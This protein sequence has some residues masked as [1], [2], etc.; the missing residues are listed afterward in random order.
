[1][2][3]RWLGRHV[4][5][6]SFWIFG[7]RCGSAGG[8]IRVDL[9][10][11]RTLFESVVY[12]VGRRRK[13]FRV[14]RAVDEGSDNGRGVAQSCAGE[15][16]ILVQLASAECTSSIKNHQQLVMTTT[17]PITPPQ[18]GC[19]FALGILVYSSRRYERKRLVLALVVVC[20]S[21]VSIRCEG[22]NYLLQL[23]Y[24]PLAYKSDY[25]S[26]MK[27]DITTWTAGESVSS[28]SPPCKPSSC[29]SAAGSSGN[30]AIIPSADN[31][32]LYGPLSAGPD[33]FG[34]ARMSPSEER[35]RSS[36]QRDMTGRTI[37]AIYPECV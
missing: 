19:L 15:W 12:Q 20:G 14:N 23:I 33:K 31:Y 7:T 2:R 32:K 29:S 37:D 5:Q 30:D 27:W 16:H 3:R 35:R 25:Q 21:D 34:T 22:H 26:I 13:A 8:L 10:Y 17:G 6:R 28:S 9:S 24:L 1:M 11:L 36:I 18:Y 4:T